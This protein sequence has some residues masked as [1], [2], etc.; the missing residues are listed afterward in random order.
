MFAP[1]MTSV[2]VMTSERQINF[3]SL[4]F[5]RRESTGASLNNAF[6]YLALETEGESGL[7]PSQRI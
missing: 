3:Q 4:I 2:I 1:V 7:A 6:D 5:K